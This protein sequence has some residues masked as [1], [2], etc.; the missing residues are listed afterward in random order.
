MTVFSRLRSRLERAREARECQRRQEACLSEAIQRVVQ[1]SAPAAWSL[2]D[3][4]RE[5]RAPVENALG[6]IQ[7]AID[8]IPGPVPLS[9][10][11]W[12]RDP[13]L[14]ALFLDA[15]E[16]R[17]LLAGNRR[18]K[19]FFARQQASRAFALLTATKIE[20]TI[21]GTAVEGHIVRRDVA[22]TAVE[23]HDHR[24]IDPAATPSETRRALQDRTLSALVNE[25]L[26]PVLQLRS[27][28][29]ELKEHQR[30]LSI[31]LKIQQTRMNRLDGR[32]P[33]N[34][35]GEPADA[36][37]PQALADID[38]QLQELAGEPDS[39][40]AYLSRLQLVLKAPQEVLRVHPVLMRLNW[41][42][43]KQCGTSAECSPE[44][45]LAEVAFKDRMKR[46]AVLVDI[47]QT[48]VTR[49]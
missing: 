9:P 14:Q 20:R 37:S 30:V 23:F 43:V 21:F 31:Q 36:R 7:Q 2:R 19:S 18:L 25:V 15:G 26:E 24:I 40:E 32:V 41:M 29:D 3:C 6:Y 47:E 17:T 1:L 16:L 44:I 27:L 35:A 12:D 10:D 34:G 8:A 33:E 13:L 38:R 49:P 46:V 28:K 22:Q 42:G 4:R 11:N 48:D 5:L 45:R 39:P